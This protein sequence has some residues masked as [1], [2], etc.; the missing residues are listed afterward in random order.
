MTDHRAQALDAL[1]AR[2][3][4]SE[5]PMGQVAPN[6]RKEIATVYENLGF[7]SIEEWETFWTRQNSQD[8]VYIPPEKMELL[9]RL[10]LILRA[11]NGEKVDVPTLYA[12]L[13]AMR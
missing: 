7:K 6:I 11:L 1:K 4:R 9:E 10:D 5:Q 3:S 8:G 13:E 12:K 2:R